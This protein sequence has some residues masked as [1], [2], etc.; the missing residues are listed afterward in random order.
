MNL[1][2]NQQMAEGVDGVYQDLEAQ[3]L[4]NI[5]RHLR[6]WDQPIATDIWYLRKLA[7]LGQLNRENIQLIARMSGISQTA[8]ERMLNEAA[9][10]AI[11]LIDPGLQ[12]LA[13]EGL[14]GMPVAAKKSR[15]VEQTV[16]ACKKQAKDTLNLCN[17]TMLYKAQAAYKGALANISQDAREILNSGAAGV[18]TGAESRGQAVRRCIKQMADKGIAAYVDKRGREWTPE[19]YVNMVMRNTAKNTADQVQDARIRDAGVNLISIDSHS[20]ARPKC[21]KDQGKIF[22]LNNGSG[23]TEDLHG[24]KIR[25][26][27]WNSSSYGEPDGILGI[28]C[29]HHKWPFIPGVNIM[30]YF[31]TEGRDMDANDRLYKQTQVQRALERDVRK[32]K[33][34][35]MMLDAAGDKE[36]FEEASVKLKNKEAALR[37]YVDSHDDLHR[38]KDREQ[39]VG[40]DKRISAEVV[41]ANKRHEKAQAEKQKAGFS[42]GGEKKAITD[43]RSKKEENETKLKKIEA[44][45]KELTKKVYFDLA[46][47]DEDMKRL[48]KLSDRKKALKSSI[49]ELDSKILDKQEAYK[50]AVEQKILE[51]GTLEE[52]KLSKRMTPE[53]VDEIAGAVKQLKKKYGVMP[54]GVVF[55]PV[56][57]P[58][59][60]ASYNWLD[61]KI[62]LSNKLTDPAK[63]AKRIKESESSLVE[64]RKHYEV[65]KTA[66]ERIEKAETILKDKTI[67]GYHRSQALIEKAE[68]EIDLN[69]S[70][71]SVRSSITDVLTHEYGHF[72]QRHAEVDYVQAKNVFGMKALGGKLMNG[73]WK[74]DI[75]TVYSRNGKIDASKL[76]KYATE[77]PYEAFAEGFLA[78][79]KGESVPDSI[80][81]VIKEA[82]RK[83]G[84]KSIY[85]KTQDTDTIPLKD[86]LIH[87]NLGAKAKNYKVIDKATGIEYEFAS[88]TRIQNAEVFAG[89]GTRHSLNEGVLEGLTKQ[90][91]GADVNGWQHAKG[92]GILV[93]PDTGEELPAEVHWFQEKSV[94][95]V[96]FKV[97]R[98][99]DE[100]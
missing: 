58:D 5:A 36:G 26:Y 89:K 92:F 17:T 96:K 38:R 1:L 63:Y 8:A 34:E 31:P 72:I 54:K 77:S 23:Y 15:N 66:R 4:Q 80:A 27:P 97:K 42:Q 86:I 61:D 43:L 9:E 81:A 12:R 49:D 56:K 21:A 71:H 95:K 29:R 59:A 78:M 45:E 24:K 35:C 14:A 75:N 32:Q 6:D 44:E 55:D 100:G 3:L 68:A 41:G 83:T 2:E 28:N 13:E 51:S 87:K 16:E 48:R 79:A 73:D 67:K 30:R 94:G 70:R 85:T 18:T 40:F 84:V 88:G 46:G 93:D 69:I 52:F 7:E 91:E 25:Y 20:G 22:D 60:T 11:S 47:T 76:S 62:Y 53:A 65:E 10:E 37:D 50:N 33:R 39:V 90:Y 64:Y 82:M 19:A 57:V 99:L 98:W 74:Y